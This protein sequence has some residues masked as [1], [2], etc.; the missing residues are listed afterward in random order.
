MFFKKINFGD[1]ALLVKPDRL[2]KNSF[3]FILASSDN[4]ELHNNIFMSKSLESAK[5]DSLKGFHAVAHFFIY[6]LF[7]F[8][9]MDIYNFQ[10]L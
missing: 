8:K 7:N 1:S 2:A 10:K 4:R 9:P 6:D 5:I 3:Y